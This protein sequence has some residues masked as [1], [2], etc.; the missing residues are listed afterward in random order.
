MIAF[1]S[2][3]ENGELV[4]KP[5]VIIVCDGGPDENPRYQRVVE[6][7]I[8]HFLKPNLDAIFVA[9]NA[10]HRSAYNRVERRMAP[11]SHAICGLVLPHDF[12]GTH[13]NEKNETVDIELEMQNFEKAGETLASIWSETVI[14]QYPAVARFVSSS[15]DRAN[16]FT[17]TIKD[18][19]WWSKHITFGQYMLQIVKCNGLSCC[20]TRRS[21]L[22][23]VLN[24]GFIPPPL[25]LDNLNGLSISKTDV[26]ALRLQQFA[27]LF[28]N[29]AINEKIKRT[30]KE[31]KV[32]IFDKFCPSVQSKLSSRTCK[33]CGQYF[34]CLKYLK[35]HEKLH[36]KQSIRK[37]GNEQRNKERIGLKIGPKRIA[38]MRAN[39]M[40]AI[41]SYDLNMEDAEWLEKEELDLSEIDL[42]FTQNI[43]CNPIVSVEKAL[44]SQWVDR[45]NDSDSDE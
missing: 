18:A 24:D 13:L 45:E 19:S 15:H 27:S 8:T 41:I 11:L 35:S 44:T 14:D 40:L 39:E 34:S 23:D 38:A 29:V 3:M 26:S 37:T 16:E 31:M 21:S 4:A 20:G 5:V 22:F 2:T 36:K 6:V 9:T 12:H 28:L 25:P 43:P 7:A 33:S 42:N 1:L 17:P 32:T 10:P 30:D